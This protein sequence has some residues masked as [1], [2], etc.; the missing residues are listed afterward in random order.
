[1][2]QIFKNELRRAFTG[3]PFFIAIA[4]GTVIAFWQVIQYVIP[5]T[6]FV[7]DVHTYAGKPGL[8]PLSVFNKWIGAERTGL[9]SYLF[10]LV[11]PLLASLPYGDSYFQ[12]RK[13]GYIRH[14]LIRQNKVQYYVAKFIAVFLSGAV[15][16]VIPLIINLGMSALILPSVLPE[17][18]THT[19]AIYAH[20]MWSS[21]YYAHPYVYIGLYLLLI[22]IFSGLWAS[23]S[24]SVSFFS[25]NRYVVLLF[26]FVFYVFIHA[27]TNLLNIDRMSPSVFLRPSQPEAYISFPI[28]LGEAV[29]LLLMTGGFFVA[30]GKADDTF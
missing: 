24:L 16:V 4:I 23:I 1:M 28:I 7:N 27:I 3:I 17:V 29:L 18:S 22:F 21:L 10:F 13:T 6:E 11:I 2:K 8:F 20:S 15:V 12:D 26:P 19:H 25:G 30:K 14:I 9:P 5:L